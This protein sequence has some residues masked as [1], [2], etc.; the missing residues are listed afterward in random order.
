MNY[1]CLGFFILSVSLVAAKPVAIDGGNITFNAPDAFAPLTQEQ[2]DKKFP[3]QPGT[4]EAVGNESGTV[5]ICYRVTE[6]D[7]SPAELPDA[8]HGIADLLNRAAPG[9]QWIKNDIVEINGTKW[10][11]FEMTSPAGEGQIHNIEITTSYHGKMFVM[12]FNSSSE[13]FD[14]N[15]AALRASLNSVKI[16]DGSVTPALPAGK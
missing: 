7:L 15:Q 8:Q 6:N 4:M 13:D 11:Y 1:L 12:N 14:S 16:R 3:R 2:I 10:I 9:L 5:T